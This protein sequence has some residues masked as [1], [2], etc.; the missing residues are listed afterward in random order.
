MGITGNALDYTYQSF[1]ELPRILQ[2]YATMCVDAANMNSEYCPFANGDSA[3][4]VVKRI[5]N[6]ITS[7]SQ[8]AGYI[9]AQPNGSP[10]TFTL[11]SF[12]NNASYTFWNPGS[13][14]AFAEPLLE[15][16]ESI[17]S[18]ITKRS[19][20]NLNFSNQ[21]IGD[22]LA[23]ATNP[24]AGDARSCIDNSF[25]L[26]NTS[27]DFINYL[28]DQ[29]AQNPLIAFN[30]L[31]DATCLNWPNLTTSDVQRYRQP[32]PGEIKNKLLV[33][34]VTGDPAC[35]FAGAV[36]TFEYVGMNNSAFLIHDAYGYGTV[37]QANN[38]SKAVLKEY[39]VNG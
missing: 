29:L 35:S 17:S 36:A 9:N 31:G 30:G 3:S 7:L 21:A 34:G 32:F 24:F 14:P 16:E 19:L 4:D 25:E 39:F 10:R 33:I 2:E 8:N 23:G 27:T 20:P 11:S 1:S 37:S 6:I 38:C 18:H 13:I 12:L 5:N 28:S 15:A 26:I 22:S